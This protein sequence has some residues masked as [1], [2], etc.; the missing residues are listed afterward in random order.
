MMHGFVETRVRHLV[1]E[2]LGVG[3]EELTPE[4]SLTDDLAAD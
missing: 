2:T 1:A 3:V 4:V